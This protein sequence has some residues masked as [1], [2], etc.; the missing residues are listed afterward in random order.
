MFQC[1]ISPD[2]HRPTRCTGSAIEVIFKIFDTVLYRLIYFRPAKERD[3]ASEGP[4]TSEF[5]FKYKRLSEFSL[6]LACQ[7]RVRPYAQLAA[8][9]IDSHS[10]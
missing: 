7:A 6:S 8:C 2:E 4:Y 9:L 1:D 5:N 3:P 10:K